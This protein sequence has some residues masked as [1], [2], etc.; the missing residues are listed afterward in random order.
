MPVDGDAA[1]RYQNN[2]DG[3]EWAANLDANAWESG[4]DQGDIEQGLEDAGVNGAVGSGVQQA[5]EQGVDGQGQDYVNNAQN[6][7]ADYEQGVDGD[8]WLQ[9]MQDATQWNV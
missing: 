2:A 7:Q 3:N 5:W 6:A 1:Q 4:V 8:A 9:S